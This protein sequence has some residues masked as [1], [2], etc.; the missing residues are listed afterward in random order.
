[1]AKKAK[2]YLNLDLP[3]IVNLILCIFLGWPLGVIER[4]VRGNILMAVLNFF[5]GFIFWVVD[6]VSWIVNKD[7]EWLV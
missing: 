4:L 6:L 1:M 3:W 2:A 7:M 5:F